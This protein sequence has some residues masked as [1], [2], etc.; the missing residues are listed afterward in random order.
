[1]RL[2][3]NKNVDLWGSPYY[4]VPPPVVGVLHVNAEP[5]KLFKGLACECRVFFYVLPEAEKLNDLNDQ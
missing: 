2:K 4:Y 5:F 1:L 3:K